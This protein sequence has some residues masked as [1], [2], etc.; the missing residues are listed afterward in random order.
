MPVLVLTADPTVTATAGQV[1]QFGTFAGSLYVHLTGA[2]DTNWVNLSALG[3]IALSADPTVTSTAG[4]LGQV[5]AYAGNLYVHL[6]SNPDVVWLNLGTSFALNQNVTALLTL[7]GA[8]ER[9][10]NALTDLYVGRSA[11]STL[12]MCQPSLLQDNDHIAFDLMGGAVLNVEIQKTDGFVPHGGGYF[13]ADV[14]GIVDAG[15]GVGPGNVVGVIKGVVEANSVLRGGRFVITDGGNCCTLDFNYPPGTPAPG[16]GSATV[17]F[18]SSSVQ[19]TGLHGGA[20]P[21]FPSSY[22]PDDDTGTAKCK[23]FSLDWRQFNGHGAV[24][25]FT[26]ELASQLPPGS[27][28]MGASAHVRNAWV[29]PFGATV[30]IEFGDDVAGVDSL[31]HRFD[32]T[33]ATAGNSVGA[34]ANNRKPG[35]ITCTVT[36]DGEGVSAADLTAG[37]AELVIF[38]R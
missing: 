24:A 9:L 37:S 33:D 36:V 7:A 35:N 6:T 32:A 13:T 18:G 3:V 20:S 10:M 8:S 28:V 4:K 19:I 38:Y 21:L 26:A 14:R 16:L 2:S 34:A 30:A 1:S 29:A 17:T 27:I 23:A 5:G 22:V 12:T 31:V 11:F 15:G 25:T